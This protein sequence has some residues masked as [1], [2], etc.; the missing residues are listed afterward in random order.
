MQP[1]GT[2][3]HNIRRP[4]VCSLPGLPGALHFVGQLHILAVD[5]KLPLFLA[6]DARQHGSRVDAHPHVH[7]GA[8]GLPHRPVD[9][10]VDS[11]TRMST[12]ERV[13]SLT[14]LWTHV[15]TDS[16]ADCRRTGKNSHRTTDHS[17]NHWER[18]LMVILSTAPR[19]LPGQVHFELSDIPVLHARP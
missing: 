19:V 18:F 1:Y 3:M 13:D 12:V 15:W 14:D 16:P 2:T 5:V 4:F 10:R 17:G 11:F 6:H 8:G 7:R 9:T